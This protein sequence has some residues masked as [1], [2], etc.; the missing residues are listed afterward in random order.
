MVNFIKLKILNIYMTTKWG[1]K[2]IK[3]V[4]EDDLMIHGGFLNLFLEK[5]FSIKGGFEEGEVYAVRYFETKKKGKIFYLAIE[6]ISTSNGKKVVIKTQVP[7]DAP[8]RKYN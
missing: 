4:K 2:I 8:F 6:A 7:F 3:G 1:S 5:S